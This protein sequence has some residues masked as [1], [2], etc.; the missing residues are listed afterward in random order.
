LKEG[1]VATTIDPPEPK[2]DPMPANY[3]MSWMPKE[4]RWKKLY[5]GTLYR[6]SCRQLGTPETKEG[7]WKAANEWWLATKSE[8]DKP[9]SDGRETRATKIGRLRR[10]LKDWDDDD[11]RQVVDSLIGPGSYQYIVAQHDE[12]ASDS[13]P[14]RADRSIESRAAEW[15]NLLLAGYESGEISA[16]RYDS[17]CL[18]IRKF[19]E[20]MGPKLPVESIDGPKVQ[21][22]YTF[23]AGKIKDKS[24]ARTTAHGVLM[25][26]KQFI[27]WLVENKE[28]AEPGNM[29]SKRIRFKQGSSSDIKTFTIDEIRAILKACDRVSEKTKLYIL[30]SL[31]VGATQMDLAELRQDEVDWDAGTVERAR[32]KTRERGG[33][34][35]KY[36]LWPETFAL[37]TKMRAKKDPLALVTGEGNPLARRWVENGKA[38]RYDLIGSAWNRLAKRMGFEKH[39]LGMKYLRKTSASILAQHPQ[40]KYY[41][42]YFLAHAPQTVAEKSYIKPSEGEFAEA[43]SWLRAQ[44]IGQG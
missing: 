35:V 31:N 14:H 19:V 27:A 16:G 22:F 15:R 44:I 17:Y 1:V 40:Y 42:T 21:G 33:P 10:A 28:I 6:V 23:L 18:N 25:T 13:K 43:L 36:Q 26:A 7:S 34:V 39:R 11:R 37:L 8:L 3:L 2:E 12:I 38:R 30:F 20:W 41:G 32:S 4:R 29:R 9:E 24:C 5:R